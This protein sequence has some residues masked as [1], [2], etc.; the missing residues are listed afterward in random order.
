MSKYGARQHGLAGEDLSAQTQQ[1]M[2]TGDP[3]QLDEV[4]LDVDSAP[5]PS[6]PVPQ[7]GI[8]TSDRML[9]QLK[10]QTGLSYSEMEALLDLLRDPAFK[11]N[12]VNC[13]HS[14][15]NCLAALPL[16]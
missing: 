6:F 14:F 9:L 2:E 10:H 11:M 1:H 3:A 16:C 12:E 5:S 13:L 15:K 8:V 7:Q 4:M